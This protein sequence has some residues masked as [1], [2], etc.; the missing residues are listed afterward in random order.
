MAVWYLM[1]ASGVVS[2]VLL[3]VVLVLGI[4]TRN[5][6][7]F[8]RAP[9][10]VT[11][12]IHRGVSLLSVVFVGVHVAT[13]VADPYAQ[14]GLVA[15]VVPF[16][17]SGNPL[18]VGLGTLSLDLVVALIVTS[19]LRRHIGARAWRLV[20]WAAYLCW[21]VAVAHTLGIG[22]DAG[23]TWL[24]VTTAVCIALVAWASATRI[25]G[26]SRGKRLEPQRRPRPAATLRAAA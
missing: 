1:R 15:T 14:V 18:W 3:T 2:L 11:A 12:G 21:P 23:T 20:H 24:R 16:A 4:A 9:A 22:S 17:G 10:F 7:R 19:L 26:R 13:A 6:V 8:G 5:R 25:A